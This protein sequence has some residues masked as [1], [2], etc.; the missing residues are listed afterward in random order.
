[1]RFSVYK[2]MLD[3]CNTLKEAVSYMYENNSTDLV[4]G[5]LDMLVSIS[6]TISEYNIT[7]IESILVL[8]DELNSQNLNLP[9]IYNKIADLENEI[10]AKAKYKLHILFVAE[11]A[12]KWDSMASVYEAMKK[13][14]DCEVE[15]V[16]QPIFRAVK[17]PDGSVKSDVI[18][19]DYLTPMGISNIPYD[20]YDFSQKLPDITFFSQ[21]YESCTIEKFWPENMAQ[22]TRVVYLPYYTART[23]NKNLSSATYHSFFKSNTEKFSWK[24]A[25]QSAKMQMHYKNI[26][27]QKGEN[28][29]V[30]GL[31]KWDS[32]LHIVKEN[33]PC[34]E[35]W[36]SKIEGR[37][38]FLWNTHFNLELD[39]KLYVE[40][41]NE[42]IS[43]FKKNKKIALIWRPHPMTETIVKLYHPEFKK[44]FEAL[45]NSVINAENMMM[46]TNPT[47]DAGFVYSDALI[48]NYSSLADQ[49]ILLDKPVLITTFQPIA[50][51][52]EY[53]ATTDG[54]YD[55]GLLP[56]A[57]AKN[58]KKDF[59]DKIANGIDEWAAKRK[60]FLNEY[61]ALADGNC[62]ERVAKKILDDFRE[63]NEDKEIEINPAKTVLI[64][65]NIKD[66]ELCVKQLQKNG[67]AVTFA[68]E[69][70]YSEECQYETV[71]LFSVTENQ[72][73]LFVVTDRSSNLV[74]DML[75]TEIGIKNEKIISF[76]QLYKA[77]LP[78]RVC[79]R[80][81]LNPSHSTYDGVILGFSNV[82]VGII[83]SQ[84]K[85]DFCNLAISSQDI[86]YNLKT[87][88][89]CYENY[90]EKLK[91][92]KYAI[93]D[94]HD[95]NYFNF[96]TSKSVS[97]VK[98]LGFG[99]Y[100]LDEHN[101]AKN[102]NYD[103]EYS[104]YVERIENLKFDGLN[105]VNVAQWSVNFPDVHELDN[106]AGFC[107]MFGDLSIRKSIVTDQHIE[108]YGY[109]RA[110]AV[111]VFE[112]TVKENVGYLENLLQLLL[113]INPEMKIYLTV[114]PK[115][116]EVETRDAQH[117]LKHKNLF[118]EIIEKLGQKFD[119]EFLDF[120]KISD[121]MY[122]RNYFFDANHLNYY[123]A[124]RLTEEL[125][126]IIFN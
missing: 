100:D 117:I 65:G 95:Y 30:T 71:S 39:V 73:D 72:F 77:S 62:G 52:R 76:W 93:V 109:D 40:R 55:M 122:N 124:M 32:P 8:S 34:P 17:M 106:F 2:S 85:A 19:N 63:E 107:S 31:P 5:C 51:A 66:S 45:K 99:G 80:I 81:M 13:R 24:I 58:D 36:K 48:S 108:S 110:S 94:L 15:V 123:G 70:L 96:D 78:T 69:F 38:V 25:A 64:V 116:V 4:T 14:D 68:K 20:Q 102:K 56:L 105:E 101:F 33:T 104:A 41:C 29:I 50:E 28:V 111:K 54:L 113:K 84:L 83:P 88:E 16:I 44:D 23:V 11:L 92:L 27:S 18:L 53:Y 21:P 89:Y 59:I 57:Y 22:F 3:M 35:D 26:G 7:D 42:I 43:I 90:Y 87:L 60:E 115:F 37:K 97:A 82:E 91:N 103:G 6:S 47:Y 12:G 61:F 112:E 86:F 74:I 46:D 9:E 121:I 120:K 49:Y 125:N 1:L 79:D 114:L 126:N 98:Y 10:K 75:K 119:F 118:Y 67:V